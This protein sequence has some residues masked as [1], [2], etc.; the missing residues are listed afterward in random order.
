MLTYAC[1]HTFRVPFVALDL[2]LGL[3]INPPM[4][5]PLCRLPEAPDVS[6]LLR[7]LSGKHWRRVQ[8]APTS[9]Q[10]LVTAE[11]GAQ[12]LVPISHDQVRAPC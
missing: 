5:Q 4:H 3:S 7:R 8:E 6:G 9:P 11:P 12:L 10:D 1:L 2:F